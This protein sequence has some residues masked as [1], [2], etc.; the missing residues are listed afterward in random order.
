MKPLLRP[1]RC[2]SLAAGM[3][4]SA[5]VAAALPLYAEDT[6]TQAHDDDSATPPVVEDQPPSPRLVIT[7]LRREGETQQSAARIT[8]VDD[9]AV[10]RRGYPTR[11]RDQL[12]NQPGVYFRANGGF[13][14][15]TALSLRGTR[16]NDVAV[17][18]DGLPVR[19]PT[20]VSGE[21]D[22]SRLSTMGVSQSEV[23]FGAH[24]GLYG[25]AA[26]GGVINLRTQR[27]TP[28]HNGRLR[29]EFGSMDTAV[30][31]GRFTGPIGEHLGYALH[32]GGIRSIGISAQYD[33]D[34]NRDGD[35]G[36]HERDGFI[37]RTARGRLEWTPVDGMHFYV[38]GQVQTAHNEY[39]ASGPDDSDAAIDSHMHRLS[40]GMAWDIDPSWRLSSDILLSESIREEDDSGYYDQYRGR[41]GYA[42]AQLTWQ[43]VDPVTA[44]LGVDVQ[45]EEGRFRED[46]NAPFGPPGNFSDSTENIGVWTSFTYDDGVMYGKGTLRHDEHEREGGATTWS[47]GAG[48]WAWPEYLRLTGHIGSSFRAPTIFELHGNNG[49]PDLEPETALS[50]SVGVAAYPHELFRLEASVYRT[51]YD[52]RIVSSFF[53][54]DNADDDSTVWGVELR[55]T[56]ADPQGDWSLSAYVNPQRSNN[57]EGDDILRTPRLLA[58]AEGSLRWREL[59]L[60]AAVQHVGKRY[61]D[62]F[63]TFPATRTALDSYTLLS[64]AVSWEPQEEWEVYLRGSNLTNAYYEDVI[65]FTTLRP[66]FFAGVV[67]RY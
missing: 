47:V 34:N 24:S 41:L 59:T 25:S 10:R 30:A 37:Q 60:S 45:R 62:D 56:L 32:V 58:G 23:L 29:A 42:Q 43:V 67:W 40:A 57:G 55:A 15:N 22:W 38:S 66:A 26:T 8:V 11:V 35:P 51:E 64:A 65:G 33:R 44:D 61:D 19:D 18:I 46:P 13:A 4:I 7:P 9:E 17:L 54:P 63:S 2:A 52:Q 50:Y 6:S 39:D 1:S 31:E 3:A 49:N 14:G 36:N 27:P 48:W 28:E 20:S 21:V 53:M 5:V 16:A 12:D